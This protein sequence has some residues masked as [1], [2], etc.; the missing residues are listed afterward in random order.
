MGLI[1]QNSR[2]AKRRYVAFK[3]RAPRAGNW[4]DWS[5]RRQSAKRRDE[6]VKR[7]AESAKCGAERD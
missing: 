2:W 5:L 7:E 1:L 6:L 3:K 4:A